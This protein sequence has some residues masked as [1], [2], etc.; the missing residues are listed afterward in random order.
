MILEIEG[1]GHSK[2][3]SYIQVLPDVTLNLNGQFKFLILLVSKEPVKLRTADGRVVIR[4]FDVSD[5]CEDFSY[6][7]FGLLVD[8]ENDRAHHY[9]RIGVVKFSDLSQWQWQR[10]REACGDL[11]GHGKELSVQSPSAKLSWLG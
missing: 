2:D 4:A 10:V 5:A 1:F 11:C 7:G 8:E 3:E 6:S 9:R